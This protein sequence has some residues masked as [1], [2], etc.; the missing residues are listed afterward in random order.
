VKEIDSDALRTINRSLGIAG[1]LAD[2]PTVL[3]DSNVA[4]VLE[5]SRL[6]NRGR[7]PAGSTGWFYGLF[8]NEHGVAG[9]LESLID[10]YAPDVN[11]VA[12]YPAIVGRDTD[13][14]LY[15]ALVQRTAGAGTLA[16]AHLLVQPDASQQGWGIDDSGV[17]VAAG[18]SFAMTRWT[19][20][21][22]SVSVGNPFGITGNGACYAPLNLR[23]PRGIVS[24]RFR[25]EAAGASA[26]F[27]C[28]VVMGLFTE[29][30]GQDLAQ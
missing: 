9:G 11:A 22:S 17:A 12:P 27:Q 19:G 13:F 10:P 20:L 7:T 3:D 18:G 16:G 23:L 8:V 25:S 15:G 21:D 2:A 14:W 28:W 6:V 1:G 30:L 5:I 26:T 4:Q 24:L 29:G